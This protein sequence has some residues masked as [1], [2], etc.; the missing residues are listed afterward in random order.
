MHRG[1]IRIKL[2]ILKP[3]STDLTI[4]PYAAKDIQDAFR[5]G[6]YVM[7]CGEVK[8]SDGQWY[9]VTL[10]LKSKMTRQASMFEGEE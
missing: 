8:G 4:T 10:T 3:S 5:A 1:C 9:V 2:Y 6:R 7:E